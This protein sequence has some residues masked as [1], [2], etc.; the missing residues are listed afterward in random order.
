MQTLKRRAWQV[1]AGLLLVLTAFGT[2]A[3][4]GRQ[5]APKAAPTIKE[6][7]DADQKDR[8]GAMS[9]SQA[10][11]KAISDRD[12]ERRRIVHQML[13]SG[14]LKTGEDFEDASVIFQ[15]GDKPE[16]YL[17]AHVLAITAMAKGDANA[18]W[19]AAATLDRY[20]QSIKQPQVFGTQYKWTEM[21]PKPHGATQAPY[22]KD[23]LSDPLRRESCVATYANQQK[24]VEAMKQGK[25]FPSPDG[26]PEKQ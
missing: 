15:H 7:L 24:N 14:A 5:Q 25:D 4:L 19:I 10:Q 17:L 23:L 2:M 20:L 18:R 13:E 12:T 3:A 6:L 26:C 11:W 9:L 16:D 21:K 22:D 1:M 8:Q